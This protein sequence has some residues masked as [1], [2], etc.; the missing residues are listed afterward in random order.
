[1]R[2]TFAEFWK[3]AFDFRGTTGKRAF[4]LTILS[5]WL[6]LFA[7]TVLTMVVFPGNRSPETPPFPLLVLIFAMMVPTAAVL[8]RRLRDAGFSPAWA[9]LFFLALPGWIALAVLCSKSSSDKPRLPSARPSPAAVPEAAPVSLPKAAAAVQAPPLK[10]EP[11]LKGVFYVFAARGPAFGDPQEDLIQEK[12][13]TLQKGRWPAARSMELRVVRPEEWGGQPRVSAGDGVVSCSLSFSDFEKEIRRYLS[14][15]GVGKRAIDDGLDVFHKQGLT[16]TNP[17]S[18]VTV[19]GVPVPDP[20]TY[21]VH[22]K[23]LAGKLLE[24][25]EPELDA[26]EAELLT[27]G[28]AAQRAIVETLE[29]YDTFIIESLWTR[30]DLLVDLL[31]KLGGDRL[32]NHLRNLKNWET[33]K[34]QYRL[35]VRQ[36]AERKLL[37]IRMEQGGFPNGIVPDEYAWA[38]LDR[39]SALESP[40]KRL[41]N[42]FALKESAV[43]WDTFHRFSYYGAMGDAARELYPDNNAHLGFYAAQASVNFVRTCTG[44]R[45]LWPDG[46]L[47]P[48]DWRYETGKM[49]EKYPLPENMEEV[50]NY[51]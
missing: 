36:P 21:L 40:E 37:A 1:M 8:V 13:E 4:W 48:G 24:G 19:M 20:E 7:V 47:S 31:C 39:I 9:L 14:E 51:R 16:I 22:Y 3:R 18:G 28:K 15:H 49:R 43:Q 17:F 25:T 34:Q 42:L 23:I 27:G 38:M 30:A 32:E 44:C 50:Q 45:L 35:L 26:M 41:E 2:K 12:A 46:I 10:E 11:P 29:Y 33:E 6:L 5:E